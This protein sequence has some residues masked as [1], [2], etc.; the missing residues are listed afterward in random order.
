MGLEGAEEL[1]ILLGEGSAGPIQ[2]QINQ[3]RRPGFQCDHH[4]MIDAE[5][6]VKLVKE[7]EAFHVCT[8]SHI[9]PGKRAGKLSRSTPMGA[10]W[11]FSHMTLKHGEQRRGL[12]IVGRE[13]ACDTGG[14]LKRDFLPTVVVGRNKLLQSGEKMVDKAQRFG[15]LMESCSKLKERSLG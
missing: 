7:G 4:L 1:P 8:A 6:V 2:C 9:R 12:R 3:M 11:M 15:L 14:R 10:D 13:D 5:R